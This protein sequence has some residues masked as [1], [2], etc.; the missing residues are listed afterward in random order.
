MNK[1]FY[2]LFLGM[3]FLLGTLGTTEGWAAMGINCI[4]HYGRDRIGTLPKSFPLTKLTPAQK[5][6][7]RQEC[8]ETYQDCGNNCD[9]YPFRK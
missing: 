1:H 2:M 5:T 9:V 7:F 6:Q 4:E 3:A 8:N